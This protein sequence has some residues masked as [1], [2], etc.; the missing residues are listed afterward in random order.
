M[1]SIWRY[2]A[3]KKHSLLMSTFW[4][5]LIWI[6][7][8]LQV[9]FRLKIFIFWCDCIL[10]CK[11]FKFKVLACGFLLH[12]KVFSP[13]FKLTKLESFLVNVV[14]IFFLYFSF[15]FQKFQTSLDYSDAFPVSVFQDSVLWAF[16]VG[17]PLYFWF[18]KLF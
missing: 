10:Y 18:K 2:I 3:I 11:A 8:S 17:P 1:I 13:F 4:I 15:P 6:E 9:L 16:H 5:K 14:L 12:E 7:F